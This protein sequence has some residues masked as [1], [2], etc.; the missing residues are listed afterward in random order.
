M[1][2]LLFNWLSYRAALCKQYLPILLRC[3]PFCD[4]MTVEMCL[5]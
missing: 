5:S 2:C 1:M 3:A 4:S